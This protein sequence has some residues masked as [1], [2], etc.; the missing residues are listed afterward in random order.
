VY[1][2]LAVAVERPFLDQLQVEVA[3]QEGAEMAGALSFVERS[4][5]A[6]RRR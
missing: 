1:E 5:A 3:P 6:A 4:A 2:L